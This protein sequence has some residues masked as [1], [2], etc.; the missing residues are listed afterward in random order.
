M[1]CATASRV[2]AQTGVPAETITRLATD[3]ARA[4]SAVCYGRVGTSTQLFGTLCQWL[5]NALNIV[6]GNLDR[7]G[8]AMFPKPAL[9]PVAL[10]QVGKG[11]YGRW[12]SR[13]RGLPEFGGELPVAVLAE[14]ILTEGEGRLRAMVTIAGNPVLSTPNGAQLDRALA[15]LDFMVSIDPYQR[16]HTAREPDPPAAVAARAT[17]LRRRVSSPRGARDRSL[18]AR[19][20]RS[21]SRRAA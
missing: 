1:R 12:K 2:A 11:S 21:G 4:P 14:E 16:D 13:V 8:G 3:F 5:V 19:A 9:D 6:T 18:L 17:A 15:S 10:K 7:E 20:L